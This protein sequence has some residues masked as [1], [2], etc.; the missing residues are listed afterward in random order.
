MRRPARAALAGAGGWRHED[1]DDET[2][3]AERGKTEASP[4]AARLETGP[5]GIGAGRIEGVFGHRE[6][7]ILP[8]QREAVPS[9]EFYPPK[10]AH[11]RRHLG[12]RGEDFFEN[13]EF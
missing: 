9:E 13:P 1:R 4:L 6:R 8:H 7:K 12:E 2:S 11:H 5:V 10:L 3:D